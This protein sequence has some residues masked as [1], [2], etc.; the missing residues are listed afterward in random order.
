MKLKLK[1]GTTSKIL[2]VFIQDV[3]A[4][5][6]GLT[7]LAYNS[8]SLVA[9]Y[10]REGDS[11]A[12]AIT[13]VSATV[14]TWVSGGFKEISSTNMPGWYE[15][16]LP[17]AALSSGASVSVML[18]GATNMA[19]LPIE[20]ELDAVDYQDAAGFGLSRLDIS[21]ASR[22]ATYTQ[23]TGFLAATFPATVSSYAGGAVASVS[24]GV[25]LA[26]AQR[27]KLDADQPDY[28]PAE[29]SDVQSVMVE[30]GYTTTRAGY[31]D[32][33]NIG[34]LVAGQS[35]VQAITQAQRVRVMP[36]P[37]MERPDDAT[38]V[39]YRVWV[40]AYNEQ[41]QAEDLDANPT[42]TAENN[43]GADRSA[44]LGTVT[45]ESGTTGIYYVDYAVAQAH[46]IEGIVFKV[47]ATENS[48]STRY[49]QASVVVDTTAVDF[50]AA[51]RMKLERL[52][53]DYT[54]ARA[55]KIDNAAS[56]A[57]DAATLAE[58]ARASAAYGS[59]LTEE[60][61]VIVS[62]ANHGNEAIKT[63]IGGL[64]TEANATA[65]KLAV[66]N[67]VGAIEGGG[68]APLNVV[69]KGGGTVIR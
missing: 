65:N 31:L 9:Y 37:Q 56:S 57:A 50:T 35:D 28:A 20:I 13:L 42:V 39:N 12:T 45:K 61:L 40:Y 69:I 59:A 1:R 46:A 15:L 17:N 10:I 44:N 11:S 47:T 68:G 5:A 16:H 58:Y 52:D 7:G 4:A 25:T 67:A 38:P 29:E 26:A 32:N 64:A 51:D 33:L 36:P 30:Q 43:A 66:L 24:A 14:G 48:I 34:G 23:P 22:M 54:T 41:H 49:A 53:A 62:D 19:Q 21:V 63:A 8:A 6:A 27:V 18:K 2:R 55:V 3:T 60:V